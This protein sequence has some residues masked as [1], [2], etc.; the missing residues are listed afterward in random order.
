MAAACRD[1]Q[2]WLWPPIR[3]EAERKLQRSF[4]DR[5]NYGPLGATL[6]GL[7]SSEATELGD[8]GAAVLCCRPQVWAPERPSAGCLPRKVSPPVMLYLRKFVQFSSIGRIMEPLSWQN[9][10]GVKGHDRQ[11]YSNGMTLKIKAYVDCWLV[12]G[13]LVFLKSSSTAFKNIA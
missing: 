9:E 1:S 6:D 3:I 11:L 5:N 12:F 13:L 2:R 8:N 4:I 7:C 10:S